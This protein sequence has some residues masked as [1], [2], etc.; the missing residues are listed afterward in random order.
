MRRHPLISKEIL[1]RIPSLQEC[2]DIPLYHHEKYDGTGYPFG[3]KGEAIPL[4][5]RLF[6]IVDVYE[7]LTSDRPYRRAWTKEKTLEYLRT[8]AGTHFDP[9]LTSQFIEM[10]KG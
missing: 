9:G 10:V 4:P 5:A 6:A 8:N 1:S 3:L 7:A 2:L